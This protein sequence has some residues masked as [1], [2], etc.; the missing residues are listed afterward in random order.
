M[1]LKIGS[2]PEAP[3]RGEQLRT[4]DRPEG[5]AQ[6]LFGN[7]LLRLSA[8]GGVPDRHVSVSCVQV[9]NAVRPDDVEWRIWTH[10]PPTGQP[11]HQ[12]PAREGVVVVTRRGCRSPWRLIAPSA[13]EKASRPSRTTGNS[14][15]PAS[16]NESGLGR[17]RNRALPQYCSNSRIWWLIAVGVTPSSA[18]AFLKLTCRAAASKA[19]S[20]MRG[21]NLFIDSSVDERFSSSTKFFAFAPRPVAVEKQPGQR[22]NSV[23]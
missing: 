6:K 12:P 11:W 3:S 14:R 1:F 19:R 23:S 2:A 5:V 9:Q 17:R 16:V 21:G 4:A 7:V 15:A 22:R 18:A 10:L 8:P 20:S 13:T